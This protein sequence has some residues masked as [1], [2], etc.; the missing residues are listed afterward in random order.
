MDARDPLGVALGDETVAGPVELRHLAAWPLLEV[1][2]EVAGPARAIG[3]IHPLIVGVVAELD[4]VRHLG[5]RVHL[6]ALGHAA[7]RPLEGEVPVRRGDV[8]GRVARGGVVQLGEVAVGVVGAGM[9]TVRR[10]RRVH[11]RGIVVGMAAGDR[12]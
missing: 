4:V 11:L 2:V 12:A 1:A 10:G 3:L 7:D 9:A 5:V 8:R 6:D